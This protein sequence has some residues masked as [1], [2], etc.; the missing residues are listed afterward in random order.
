MDL[1]FVHILMSSITFPC[2]ESLNLCE[3][4]CVNLSFHMKEQ[5]LNS[6]SYSRPYPFFTPYTGCEKCFLYCW[7][8]RR[9][10]I[11]FWESVI[12]T[13]RIVL[14]DFYLLCKIGKAVL[15]WKDDLNYEWRD[16]KGQ[17]E[18]NTHY[19]TYRLKNPNSIPFPEID[20]LQ[21]TFMS[22]RIQRLFSQ[23][24]IHI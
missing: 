9:I 4:V 8:S 14:V 6:I 18:L 10:E 19:Y 15:G 3:P 5:L 1:P 16:G 21:D 24:R 11:T 13:W 7:L 23:Q 20:T 12:N 2:R 22:R 17:G